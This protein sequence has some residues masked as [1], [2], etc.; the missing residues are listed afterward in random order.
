M[1]FATHLPDPEVVGQI[2]AEIRRLND[3]QQM[4]TDA[5][6]AVLKEDK[7]TLLSMGFDADHID[8]LIKRK[9]SGKSAFPGYALRN[10]Q[11]AIEHLNTLLDR[12]RR[13]L[14]I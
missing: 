2:K 6:S 7:N 14:S 9:A 12:A 8:D 11:E 3:A 13:G 1:I 10:N 5:N 4:M